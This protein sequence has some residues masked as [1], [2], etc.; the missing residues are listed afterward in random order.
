V[1]YRTIVADPP[2]HY[3]GFA[4]SIG[5][6][7]HF[8]GQDERAAVEVKPLPY[9]SMSLEQIA[10]LPISGLADRDCWLFLWT[11]N[12]YLFDARRIAEG[13]GFDYAQTIVWR[14]TSNV[15]P[16]GGTFGP[17]HAEFLLACRHGSPR[18]VQRWPASVIEA[19]KPNSEHSRK[20]EVF[21]D[22]IESST[23]GPYVELFARRARFG[24]SYWG[25]ES[26]GTAD[27]ERVA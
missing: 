22:L 5:Y 1:R 4:G 6:G 26:L 27:L 2:W 9:A 12:R 21:L 18:V 10:A 15:P 14:K 23:G 25:D 17:N 16:F 11:T 8:A 13:W 19:P 24:W 3:D 7:G 20:P